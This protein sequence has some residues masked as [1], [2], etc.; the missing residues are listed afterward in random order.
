VFP[1]AIAAT[2]SQLIKQAESVLNGLAL[3]AFRI[4]KKRKTMM[5]QGLVRSSSSLFALKNF[6]A[7]YRY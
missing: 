2:A 6:W 4:I 1:V 7:C 5:R 3:F